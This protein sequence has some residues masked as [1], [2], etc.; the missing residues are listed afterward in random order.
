M[1]EYTVE[2]EKTIAARATSQAE[3]TH[4]LFWPFAVRDS[5]GMRTNW[6]T[7]WPSIERACIARTIRF[8]RSKEIISIEENLLDRNDSALCLHAPPQGGIYYTQLNWNVR[9]PRD[10]PFK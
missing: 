2:L 3:R 4:S 8:R 1:L 10:T 7:S 6:R 5:I 9:P